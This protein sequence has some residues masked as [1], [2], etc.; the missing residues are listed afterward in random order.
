MPKSPQ[1]K[2]ENQKPLSRDEKTSGKLEVRFL[3]YAKME[4]ILKGN[5]VD[6]GYLE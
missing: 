6:E 4:R 2:I 1:N 5:P 3:R